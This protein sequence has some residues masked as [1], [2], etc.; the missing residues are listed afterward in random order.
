MLKLKL[1][2]KEST[3]KEWEAPAARGD[4]KQKAAKSEEAKKTAKPEEAK[5]TA[6]PED[7]KKTTQNKPEEGTRYWIIYIYFDFR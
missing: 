1:D 2:Y 5:K 3:G 7:A 6:K 4:S